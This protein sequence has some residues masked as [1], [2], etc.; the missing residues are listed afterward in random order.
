ML[1]DFDLAKPS[2]VNG[3]SPATIHQSELNGVTISTFHTVTMRFL[4][5]DPTSFLS[6]TPNHARLIFGPIRLWEPKVCRDLIVLFSP[7]DRT[8]LRPT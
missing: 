3:G 8:P 5:S 7:S 1:S 6:L 4:M 2:G